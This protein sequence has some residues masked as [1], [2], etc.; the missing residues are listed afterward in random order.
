MEIAVI[1]QPDFE[2]TAHHDGT[3][4]Q[5]LL[6]GDA[7]GEAFEPFEKLL[8][9]L[10][11]EAVDRGVSEAAIDMRALEFMSSSCFKCLVTWVT[12]IQSLADGKQYKLRF[13]SNPSAGWQKR[14]LRSLSCFAVDLVTIEA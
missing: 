1:K 5:L 4:I 8:T 13:I 7:S 3:A 10:H 2:A 14:S 6:K 9:Q 12:D 11:G